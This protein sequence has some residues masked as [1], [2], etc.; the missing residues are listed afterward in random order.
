MTVKEIQVINYQTDNGRIFASEAEAHLYEARSSLECWFE[1]EG[2]PSSELDREWVIDVIFDQ[3]ESLLPII[4]KI[5]IYKE[6]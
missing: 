4:E 5:K 3:A 1:K 2:F 6:T